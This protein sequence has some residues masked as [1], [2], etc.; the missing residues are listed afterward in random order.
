[1]SVKI[2]TGGAGFV[3][4]RLALRLQKEFPDDMTVVVDDFSS[5]DFRNLKG[6]RGAIITV[7]LTDSKVFQRLPIPINK[8]ISHIFHNAA[9]T[10]TEVHDQ[11]RMMDVN[12]EATRCMTHYAQESG[13]KLICASSSAVYGQHSH[14]P[15]KVGKDENPLNIYAFSK[16]KM[17][18]HTRLLIP[19]NMSIV[20]LRYFNVYG[21]GEQYKGNAASM[22]YKLYNQIKANMDRPIVDLFMNSDRMS[23]DWIHVN[24]VVEAN[25][26]AMDAEPGIYN[27]GSGKS[28]TFKDLVGVIGGHIAGLRGN[29]EIRFIQNRSPQYYQQ[30]TNA[31][32]KDT[33]EAFDGWDP[34]GIHKGVMNYVKYLEKTHGR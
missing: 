3:G 7:D 11:Y 6:F 32:I 18:H 24:D 21:P 15:M 14:N 8:N 12:M 10:N 9:I 30:F 16:L 23:R 31:C 13:A 2:V 26:A 34:V 27:V 17:D 1:M 29:P 33:K 22:I 28:T 25:L 20:N 5:G 4:S 19:Q